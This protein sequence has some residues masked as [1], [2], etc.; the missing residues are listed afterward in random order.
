MISNYIDLQHRKYNIVILAGG[1][2]SRLGDQSTYIPKALS[3]FGDSIAIN[4]LIEQFQG[5]AQ[6]FIVGTGTHAHL[7]ESHIKGCYPQYPV[8]F[9]REYDLVNNARSFMY[10]MDNVDSRFPTILT[11][12]DAIQLGNPIIEQDTLYLVNAQTKGWPSTYRAGF[13]NADIVEYKEPLK[14]GVLPLWV[15]SDTVLLKK[16]VYSNP[17][18]DDLIKYV[19]AYHS[20]KKMKPINVK[21]CLEFGTTTDLDAVRKIWWTI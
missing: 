11:F 3:S 10:A 5:I 12:C 18:A 4:V 14:T 21:M 6:K 17:D 8:T 7:L 1:K 20:I 15:F 9:S 16:I 19:R 2:G 13:E